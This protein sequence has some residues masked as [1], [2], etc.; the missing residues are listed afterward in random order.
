MPRLRRLLKL[1]G[2][3]REPANG[4]GMGPNLDQ[5]TELGVKTNRKRSSLITNL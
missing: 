2:E 4:I 3:V 1:S 5:N